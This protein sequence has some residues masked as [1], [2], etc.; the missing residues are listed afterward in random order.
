MTEDDLYRTST[1][2]RLWSFTASSLESL[3][4]STNAT[5]TQRVRAAVKRAR[6]SRVSSTSSPNT[7]SVNASQ[8]DSHAPRVDEG[9]G[10]ELQ[11]E[12]DV[13]CLTVAEEQKLVQ[14]YCVKAMEMADFCNFPTNV[15]A[16]A[17][18]FMKR[19]YLFNSPMTYHPRSI[20]PCALFLATKTETHYTSLKNFASK[21]PKTTAE[22]IIAPEFLITQA[23]RFT[24]DVRHPFRSL[25]GGFMELLAMADG[26]DGLLKRPAKGVMHDLRL[27]K[28]L[29]GSDTSGQTTQQVKNRIR[30]A[31]GKAKEVLKTS[32]II[33]D[34]YFLYTPAQIWLA[35]LLVVDEPLALFYLDVKFSPPPDSED[36]NAGFKPLLKTKLITSLR[37]LAALLQSST[38]GAAVITPSTDE[39]AELRRIDKKLYKCR[40][41]EKIDLVGLNQAVK[42]EGNDVDE[43]D[44]NEEEKAAKK[45]KGER[46]KMQ[47]EGEDVFGGPLVT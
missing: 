34:A 14:Y 8:V 13:E 20:M 27:L 44:R 24:F 35:S 6:E 9:A 23:L 4:S 19:F 45:R 46:E 39:I 29:S 26:K 43:S 1:Q 3:R 7:S 11:N 5:A 2:Y 42:R 36:E 30:E 41:P 18:Q 12:N 28:R 40:N 38:A 33:S 32:A 22:D 47:R 15:K 37:S 16:T 21:V 25:E 17:V 31:H 10:Y